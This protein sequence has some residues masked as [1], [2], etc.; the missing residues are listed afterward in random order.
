[1]ALINVGRSCLEKD[2][3]E[4]LGAMVEK[5]PKFLAGFMDFILPDCATVPA[6]AAQE[7]KR[8]MPVMWGVKV[9][10]IDAK[11]NEKEYDSPSAALKA[12]GVS[13]SGIQCDA[14]GNRCRSTSQVE[15]LQIKGYTVWGNGEGTEPVKGVS[16]HITVLHPEWVGQM[17]KETKSR[18]AKK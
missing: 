6:R 4:T 16:K 1:M 3:K 7:A 18:K 2:V 14:D 5:D 15:S 12:L 9:T 13:T 8:S 10:Y 11:G 17:H